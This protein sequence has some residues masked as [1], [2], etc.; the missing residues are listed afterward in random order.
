M[1]E[2]V[3]QV[4]NQLK[5]ASTI[6]GYITIVIGFYKENPGVEALKKL[7]NFSGCL[8][9]S[10]FSHGNIALLRN[11]WAGKYANTYWYE[12]Y[13]FRPE[14]IKF[15]Q[16]YDFFPDRPLLVGSSTTITAIDFAIAFGAKKIELVGA[17]GNIV[18][19]KKNIRGYNNPTPALRIRIVLS[20]YRQEIQR[21]CD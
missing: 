9:V 5:L 16:I 13:N 2:R 20:I 11:T 17:T 1:T 15:D 18:R 14:G 6:L 7:K 8:C 3:P 10:E 4:T 12:H 21:M 19:G